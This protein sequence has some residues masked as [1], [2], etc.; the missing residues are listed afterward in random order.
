MAIIDEIPGIE[1]TIVVNGQL[2][3]EYVDPDPSDQKLQSDPDCPICTRY[4]EAVEGHPF[5]TRVTFDRKEC[6][7]YVRGGEK[8]PLNIHTMTSDGANAFQKVL[9]DGTTPEVAEIFGP[10]QFSWVYTDTEEDEEDEE[11]EDVPTNHVNKDIKTVQRI[12][13]IEVSITP[14]HV[15]GRASG[16]LEGNGRFAVFRFMYRPKG[17]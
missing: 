11:D 5:S 6:K 10:T 15:Y 8:H 1:V 16:L 14:P 4:I 7:K 12:G 9:F 13:L 2:A 3:D 17:K